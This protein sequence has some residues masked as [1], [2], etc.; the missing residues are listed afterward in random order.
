VKALV[1]VI[2]LSGALAEFRTL[3]V[4]V[5]PPILGALGLWLGVTRA[6]W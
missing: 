3:F 1:R 6:S 5:L 2:T 4:V